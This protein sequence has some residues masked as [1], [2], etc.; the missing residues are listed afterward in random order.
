MVAVGVAVDRKGLALIGA[1][2]AAPLAVQKPNSRA[3]ESEADRIG[4]IIFKPF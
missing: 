1:A 2:L 3:A 4:L